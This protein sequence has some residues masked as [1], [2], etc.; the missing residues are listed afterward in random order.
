MD[1]SSRL[2]LLL[3]LD[4]LKSE[5]ATTKEIT[6]VLKKLISFDGVKRAV[7]EKLVD[8]IRRSYGKMLDSVKRRRSVT[9]KLD[10][11]YRSF[12]EFSV[13]EGFDLCHT[14]EKDL[15]LKVP[16]ILWQLLLEKE[17]V[18]YLNTYLVPKNQSA[19]NQSIT[20]GNPRELSNIE[21]NAVRYTAGFVIHKLQERYKKG[22]SVLLLCMIWEGR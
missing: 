17:F 18:C 22:L 4:E 5:S 2:T 15:E 12:H 21:K 10:N 13:N 1:V 14:C 8:Q 7:L 9:S 11:L 19:M 20:D 16:E 3:E 6:D